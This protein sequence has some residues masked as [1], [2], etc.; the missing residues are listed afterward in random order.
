MV[1]KVPALSWERGFLLGLARSDNS[2]PYGT[3]K[4]S[5]P[6]LAGST[7]MR[8]KTPLSLQRMKRL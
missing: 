5:P 8:P 6:P 7:K 4:H 2:L 3:K 1:A